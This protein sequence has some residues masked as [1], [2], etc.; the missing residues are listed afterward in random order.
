M[1]TREPPQTDNVETAVATRR[2]DAIR[3]VIETTR[4]GERSDAARARLLFGI[5]SIVAKR[6]RSR[7]RRLGAAIAVAAVVP[8]Y[9]VCSRTG[10]HLPPSPELA[11]SKLDV[12]GVG[13]LRFSEGARYSFVGG[14]CASAGNA[15]SA[16]A[17]SVGPAVQLETGELCAIIQ[18]RDL[19][20]RPPFEVHTAQLDVRDLGTMFCVSAKKDLSEVKVTEGT[21]WIESK[22]SGRGRQLGPGDSMRSD[23]PALRAQPITPLPSVDL[24]APTPPHRLPVVKSCSQRST[25]QKQRACYLI[26]SG[27]SSFGAENALYSLALMDADQLG[28]RDRALGELRLYQSRYPRGHLAPEVSLTLIRLLAGKAVDDRLIDETNRFLSAYPAHPKFY[29]VALVRADSL[30][31]LGRRAE[32]HQG[33]QAL[34]EANAPVEISLAARKGMA[35][36]TP[37]QQSR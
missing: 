17:K 27:G 32:A 12:V 16:A 29:E 9:L 5:R 25:V 18:H 26:A 21:V 2:E 36:S 37:L 15:F 24:V 20:A 6:R 19:A 33:Y 14:A 10:L 35:A 11:W 30:L 7:R 1:D 4:R 31:S 8:L 28:D 3:S 23:E 22:V 34:L 13:Q